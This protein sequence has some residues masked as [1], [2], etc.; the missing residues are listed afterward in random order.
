[1]IKIFT[2]SYWCVFGAN[3]FFSSKFSGGGVGAMPYLLANFWSCDSMYDGL[4]KI[5]ILSEIF[6]F[7]TIFIHFA[8]LDINNLFTTLD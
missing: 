2:F 5:E 7:H 3:N 4:K 6:N 1:M 8:L